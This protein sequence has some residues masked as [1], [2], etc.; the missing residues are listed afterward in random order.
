ML[1]SH[2]GRGPLDASVG[3]TFSASMSESVDIDVVDEIIS[4][5][6]DATSFAQ[7]H[8]AYSTVLELK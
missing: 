2:G 4:H 6:R 8:E 5:A 7:V 1:H 3:T